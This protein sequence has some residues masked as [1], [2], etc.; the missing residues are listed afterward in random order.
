[1]ARFPYKVGS[2]LSRLFFCEK[3]LLVKG[4]EDVESSL[5]M[6]DEMTSQSDDSVRAYPRKGRP[7]FQP[8]QYWEKWLP[9][10]PVSGGAGIR[11]GPVLAERASAGK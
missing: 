9:S 7:P 3:G 6:D 5:T 1:M 11:V 2:V 10:K 8:T 4:L